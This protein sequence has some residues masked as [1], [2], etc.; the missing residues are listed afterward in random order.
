MTTT[1]KLFRA[2]S[3]AAQ[4]HLDP[5]TKEVLRYRDALWHGVNQIRRGIPLS[6]TLYEDLVQIVK[7][8]SQG[9]RTGHG[10]KLQDQLTKRIVYS[11][12]TGKD[13]ISEKLHNLNTFL[14]EDQILDPLI[15]MAL[16]H[17]QFEAIHPF[18]DGNGRVGRILMILY[19]L[20]E[21]LLSEPILFLS[22]YIIENK[23][24]YYQL[25]ND[26]TIHQNWEPWILFMI[27]GVQSTSQ[28]TLKQILAIHDLLVNYSERVQESLPKIHSKELIE[29]LFELPYSKVQNLVDA[30]IAKRQT[31]SRYLKLF[32]SHGFLS[33]IKIVRETVYVNDEL[34]E[35]LSSFPEETA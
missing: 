11:P 25:L 32:A 34:M 6:S 12:P 4:N 30:Q 26:V 5:L 15:K 3:L 10:T 21:S 9:I 20:S 19:L 16:I 14:H 23:S 17:Y 27:N 24:E 35:L 33:S 28:T 1:D 2:F 29:T 13:L 31:A 18:Y 7:G 8:N 22:Q